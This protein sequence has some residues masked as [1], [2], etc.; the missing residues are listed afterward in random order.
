MQ[1]LSSARVTAWAKLN[2]TKYRRREGLCLAEGEKVVRELLRSPWAVRAVLM[3]EDA[4]ARHQALIA[5]LPSGAVHAVPARSWKRISQDPAPEG[6]LAVAALPPPLA[7]ADWETGPGP[8]LLIDRVNNPNNLGALLRTAHWFGF[9]TVL[10]GAGSA[11]WTH[12]KVIR[13]S[14]GSLF[15]LNVAADLDLAAVLPALRGRFRLIGSDVRRGVPPHPCP[16]QTALLLGNETH[17]LPPA[18]LDLADECWRIPGAG[19]AESLSL[20]QAAAIMM[21]EFRRGE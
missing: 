1:A 13:T 7:A 5:S 3:E 19:D 9:R 21:Y 15:H 17:G 18:L 4:A 2:Q 11:D 8:L 20:P 14:M 16:P 12:P 6:I 10:V